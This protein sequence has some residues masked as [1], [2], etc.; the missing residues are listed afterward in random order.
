VPRPLSVR[1]TFHI[2]DQGLFRASLARFSLDGVC[3]G[4]KKALKKALALQV[5]RSLQLSCSARA[6]FLFLRAVSLGF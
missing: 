2:R 4:L 1:L 6:R 5:D 3:A